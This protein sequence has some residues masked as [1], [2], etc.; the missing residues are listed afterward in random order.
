M[1]RERG[2]PRSTLNVNDNQCE[3]PQEEREHEESDSA[4]G[5]ATVGRPGFFG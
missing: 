3:H 1:D 5:C 4:F 2:K